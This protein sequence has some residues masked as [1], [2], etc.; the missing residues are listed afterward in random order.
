MATQLNV[1]KPQKRFDFL[2]ASKG[3]GIMLVVLGHLVYLYSPLDLSI[4]SFHMPFFFLVS[5]ACTKVEGISFKDYFIKKFKRL[6]LAYVYIFIVG[7]IVTYATP[8]LENPESVK[9]LIHG[10]F[11]RAG[12]VYVG[13]TWFLQCLFFVSLFLYPF[14]KYVIKKM[15][16][17]VSFV[18]SALLVVSPIFLQRYEVQYPFRLNVAFAMLPIFTI[19]CVFRERVFELDSASIP[20]RLFTAVLCFATV[21]IVAPY[22]DLVGVS[23]NFYGKDYL[24]YFICAIA[25][26]ALVLVLGTFVKKSYVL[27]Y[28]G[29]NSMVIF[30]FH[31]IFLMIYYYVLKQIYHEELL[32]Q[33]NL[34]N[35]Q[36]AVGF[37]TVLAASVMVSLAYNG[38][39]MLFG[40]LFS[41]K[42]KGV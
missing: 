42:Q 26:S 10:F 6:F 12:V 2:D 39:K 19:G 14:Y 35:S 22:N 11:Y 32:G 24:L 8:I 3:L 41:K 18:I 20:K 28:I 31:G 7:T 21:A 36:V 25:G 15:P 30:S 29:K 37:V 16:V 34:S 5:G 40:K 4:Y 23:E 1:K 33:K 38:I 9:D 27:K 17:A 13:V